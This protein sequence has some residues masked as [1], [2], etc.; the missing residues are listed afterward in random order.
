M[1]QLLKKYKELIMYGIFGVGATLINILSYQFFSG[2]IGIQ[3]MI[4]NALAWVLAFVFAFLTNKLFVFESKS[5][6]G[7]T[8]IQEAWNF[9]FARAAT[10][11]LDMVLMW[12]L[13][14]VLSVNELL[15]KIF[16]NVLVIIINYIASKFWIFSKKKN[17]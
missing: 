10:G 9:F 4:S 3:Y 13:I 5:W 6:S 1:R 15:S 16:V 8:A 12:L 11:V 7:S 17:A 14:G 2:V